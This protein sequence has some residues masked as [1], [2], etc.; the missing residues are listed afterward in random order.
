[1]DEFEGYL[2]S[3][4]GFTDYSNCYHKVEVLWMITGVCITVGTIIS[5]I[6]QIYNIVKN[7]SSYGI[8]AFTL[9]AT[10]LSQVVNVLNYCS[11]HA[12]DFVGMVSISFVQYMPRMLSFLN[13]FSLWYMYL[14]NTFLTLIFFDKKPREHR[15]AE[16]IKT[17][18]KVILAF[19]IGLHSIFIVLIILYFV[20]GSTNGY[21]ES[22]LR[23]YGY[24]LGFAGG[25]IAIAQYAPQMY[26]TCKLQSPG[27]LS[28]V[29]LAIQ[30]PG[31]T[32]NSM[33]LAF[34]NKD[35]WT[36]WFPLIVGAMQQFILLFICI[37]YVC[38]ARKLKKQMMDE[39]PLISETPSVSLKSSAEKP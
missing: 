16:Q 20:F 38:K 6:P 27:S 1:M 15:N 10:S 12:A 8:N 22:F 4:A 37:Y 34:G 19:T 5:I 18:R 31:G 29:L 21:F 2:Y 25:V 30:A 24:I 35:N 36:T 3:F 28:I 39:Q 33:F 13:I 17:N 23:Q 9:S 7:K 14:G 11:L 26:T 32:I